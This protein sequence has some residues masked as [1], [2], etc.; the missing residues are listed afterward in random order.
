[1]LRPEV[2]YK[3]ARSERKLR[4]KTLSL[5]LCAIPGSNFDTGDTLSIDT[6]KTAKEAIVLIK[7]WIN[8]L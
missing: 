1:M 8:K 2:V 6:E 4:W 7:T 3:F 5:Y